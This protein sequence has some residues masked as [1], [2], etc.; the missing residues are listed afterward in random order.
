MI[1]LVG[2]TRDFC[3]LRKLLVFQS[4]LSTEKSV[5]KMYKL[6]VNFSYSVIFGKSV[7]N[8]KLNPLLLITMTVRDLLPPL[9]L[10]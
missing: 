9:V 3:L 5:F 8:E 2:I 10:S 7:V 1:H 4:S 6:T